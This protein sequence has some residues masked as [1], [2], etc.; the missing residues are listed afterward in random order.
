MEGTQ[1]DVTPLPVFEELDMAIFI[2]W[3]DRAAP[4]EAHKEDVV[5]YL[6]LRRG[7]L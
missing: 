3:I 1:F 6:S 7:S 4:V 2:S 5:T